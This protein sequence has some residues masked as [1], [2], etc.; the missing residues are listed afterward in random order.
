MTGAPLY[1]RWDGDGMI[2]IGRY[3]REA[4]ER[5]VVGERY[6]MEVIEQRSQA[7][8]AFYFAR[9]AELWSNLPERFGDRF[10]SPD[11][12]RAYALV[13]TGHCEENV[14]TVES[15]E[16]AQRVG[17]FALALDDLCIIDIKGT[18]VSVFKAHS[19]KKSAMDAQAFRDSAQDVIDFIENE[20]IGLRKA[21]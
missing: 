4:N 14:V 16:V 12:L 2:P 13:H 8:H 10:K 21:G 18:V 19:Q 9:V 3:V 1:F 11:H 6:Q 5:F 17:A 15:E 7:F 20:M